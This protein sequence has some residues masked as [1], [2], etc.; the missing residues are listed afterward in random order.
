MGMIIVSGA[1]PSASASIFQC[2]LI[3]AASYRDLSTRDIVRLDKV[4]LQDCVG[5]HHL[6]TALQSKAC[7]ITD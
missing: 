1:K 5:Y 3:D 2:R 7:C 4:M 6:G